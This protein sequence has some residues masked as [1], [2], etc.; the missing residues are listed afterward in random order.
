VYINPVL[1]PQFSN[2]EDLL[3]TV[4]LFDDDTGQ[5]IKVDGC[6][7]ALPFAFTGTAWTVTDG[8]IIT[9]LPL[10]ATPGAVWN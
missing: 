9:K 4:S 8:P 5:P 10:S 6:T 1:L 2:R 3:L 7:T